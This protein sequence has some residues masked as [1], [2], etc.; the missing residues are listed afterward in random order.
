MDTIAATA[1]PTGRGSAKT[2]APTLIVQRGDSG[3][4]K[5]TVARAIRDAYGGRGCAIIEQDYLRRFVLREHD[6]RDSGGVVPQFITHTAQ[7][8]LQHGYHTIVEGILA[9][10]RYRPALL[11]LIA[12]HTGDAFVYYLDAAF[13]ETVRRHHTRPQA[14][15]FT[16]AQMGDWFN[17]ADHLGTLGELIIPESSTLDQTVDLIL[18]HSGLRDTP[19]ITYCPIRCGRCDE[20]RQ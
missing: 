11:D 20:E 18:A 1:S 10:A 7:F 4:G 9:T 17:A 14:E 13:A 8:A 19:P 12:N 3:S 2:V 16:P 6:H 15:Q 5:S